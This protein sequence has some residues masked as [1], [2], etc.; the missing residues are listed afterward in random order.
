MHGLV[1]AQALAVGPVQRRHAH[2]RHLPRIGQRGE[3]DVLRLRGRLEALEHVAQRHA[4]PGDDHR[5]AFDAAHAVDAFLRRQALQQVLE[6]HLAGLRAMPAHRDRPRRGAQRLGRSSRI[7]LGRAEFVEIVVAGGV[8]LAGQFLAGAE[9]AACLLGG[10]DHPRR[11]RRSLPAAGQPERGQRPKRRQQPAAVVVHR[12]G[13]NRAGGH[14]RGGAETHAGRSS[15][16]DGRLRLR[17][18]A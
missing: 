13:G 7:V 18:P 10:D 6:R 12:F 3:R 5:P 9:A 14:R 2:A 16:V 17:T 15:G 8:R 11:R 1:D 4:E